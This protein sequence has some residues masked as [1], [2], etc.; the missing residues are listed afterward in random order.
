[1]P[2]PIRARKTP[3]GWR[4]AKYRHSDG[5]L[6]PCQVIAP[7]TGSTWNIRIPALKGTASYQRSNVPVAT[8]PRQSG[9]LYRV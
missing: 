4:G 9:A 1:M 5:Q 2:T 7:G 6:Y 3:S 8:G